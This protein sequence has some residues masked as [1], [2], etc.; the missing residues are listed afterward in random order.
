MKIRD[1]EPS[2]SRTTLNRTARSTP[3]EAAKRLAPVLRERTAETNQLRRLPDATWSDL[4]ETGI[5]RALQPARWGGGEVDIGEFF[6]AVIEVARAEGS[7]GWVTGIIGVHPWHTALYSKEAQYEMWQDDPTVM[8]S[9]SYAPTG[10]AERV[11]GGYRLSGRWS[12][13]SGC[14]HCQW[15]NLAAVVG[16]V[17]VEG[18][19]VPDFRS[20]LLPRADYKIDDNWYVTGLK[21]TGSKD[22]AVDNAF[23]PD[24]RSMSHWDDKAGHPLPGWDFN[25]AP[26]YRLPWAV[27][28]ISGL[29]AGAL[30]ASLGFLEAWTEISRTRRAGFGGYAR[31]DPYSQQ[32]AAEAAYTIHGG[33]TRLLQ[34]SEEMME[35]A[36]AG[37]AF[38]LKQ[39]ARLRYNAARSAQLAAREVDRLYEASSGRTVF[40]DHPLQRR[41]QDVKAM[42][43]HAGLN[44]NVPGKFLGALEFGLPVLNPLL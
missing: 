40:L 29:S 43:G 7:T 21:G 13:S 25:P 17:K 28:F 6:A 30:G 42:M 12:F 31:D 24:H 18:N 16:T 36:R 19:E 41:Y 10:N 27:V 23:V 4:I 14:D 37:E 11:N 35:T 33:I 15:V 9:S 22:I 44:P 20:F 32:L 3:V 26:L 1:L 39:R 2:A 8:N 5:L 34:D 38:S